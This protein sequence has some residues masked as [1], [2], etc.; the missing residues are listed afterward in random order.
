MTTFLVTGAAGGSGASCAVKYKQ[1]VQQRS[2]Y[3]DTAMSSKAS[4]LTEN[5]GRSRA[6]K[7]GANPSSWPDRKHT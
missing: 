7:S 4:A 5:G 1:L 6:R 2:Q 3:V